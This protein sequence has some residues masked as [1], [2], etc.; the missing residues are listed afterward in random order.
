MTATDYKK[1]FKQLKKKPA[2]LKKYIKHNSP[3]DRSCGISLKKCVKCNRTRAH[4][5][6]YGLHL[7]RQ[8][9]RDHAEDIGFKQYS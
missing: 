3:K 5:S 4:I 8:C 2:K 1:V 6:K 9:F 7:C